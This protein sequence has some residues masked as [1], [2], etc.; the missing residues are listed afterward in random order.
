MTEIPADFRSGYVAIIGRPNVGKSTLVNA[1]L[2]FRLSIATHKPQTTRH[3]ILGILNEEKAQVIFLDTPGLIQPKYK[4]QEWMMKAAN[5]AIQEADVLLLL[6]EA[7]AAPNPHDRDLLA[8]SATKGKPIVLAINKI[9]LIEKSSLLPL[10]EAFRSI[11]QPEAVVPISALQG[12]NLDVLKSELLSLLP[13]GPPF[14]PQD[15]LTDHP[16][17]FF[18]GELI[19][20]Q[21]FLQYGEEIPYSSTVVID[22]FR[23]RPQGK[24][25]I[26]AR[27][28]VERD[29]QKKII[30]GKEGQAIRRLGEKAREA[31]EAFLGRPV[32]LQ[33]FVAVRENWR[34]KENFLREFGY[35][36]RGA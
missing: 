2:Q 1:L 15:T 8:E 14:Y 35:D 20:E 16:E 6:V 19:R 12:E 26:N 7:G 27:I 5:R 10:I 21:I 33:L 23:E 36:L 32:Y 17:R 24:D 11:H 29:S 25:F 3:T 28:I 13:F 4:L 18:V 9:D 22:E 30:I 31:I 34:K